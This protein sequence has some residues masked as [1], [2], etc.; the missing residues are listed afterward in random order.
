MVTTGTEPLVR[1]ARELARNVSDALNQEI[2][3]QLAAEHRDERGTTEAMTTAD[4]YSP[5]FGRLVR[6]REPARARGICST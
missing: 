5:A 1:T 2:R 3:V 6:R 4:V